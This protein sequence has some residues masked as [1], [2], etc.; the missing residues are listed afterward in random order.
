MTLLLSVVNPPTACTVAIKSLRNWF[1][2]RRFIIIL[3]HSIKITPSLVALPVDYKQCPARY[4]HR[5][6]FGYYK[7]LACSQLQRGWRELIRWQHTKGA[8]D[9]IVFECVCVC[10]CV[11]SAQNAKISNCTSHY[12][13]CAAIQFASYWSKY[14][15]LLAIS[16][17]L[18][19]VREWNVCIPS[20]NR[21]HETRIQFLF[22]TGKKK[23]L[24]CS[25]DIAA[26][27]LAKRYQIELLLDTSWVAAW[28]TDAQKF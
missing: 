12:F 22:C 16:Q 24:F 10:V 13:R 9:S 19:G 2:N 1:Q 20:V 18:F 8:I 26:M 4:F 21:A 11:K 17:S 5:Q 27:H 6:S 15:L 25:F 14:H 3:L 28:T 7:S 23:I